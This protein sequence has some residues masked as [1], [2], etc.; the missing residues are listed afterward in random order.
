VKR[1]RDVGEDALRGLLLELL[2]ALLAEGST[3][4]S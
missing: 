2:E 1:R 4:S 3:I